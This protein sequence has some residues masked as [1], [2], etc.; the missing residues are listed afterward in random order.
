RKH[1][2][3][4]F[5]LHRGAESHR[6]NENY[7]VAT[8][9]ILDGRGLSTTFTMDIDGTIYQHFDPAFR[10]G[11][12]ATYHNIQSDSMDIGGPFSQKRKKEEGQT[13]LTLK[14]AIGRTNDGVPP[15]QRK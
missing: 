8:E 12:H 11:R 3:T 7:A 6:K 5:V 15:L 13:P 10:R 4:Q 1:T 14:M 9:R 2:V